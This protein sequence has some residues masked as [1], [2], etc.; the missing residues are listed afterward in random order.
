VAHDALLDDDTLWTVI[1]NDPEYDQVFVWYQSAHD[2][3]EESKRLL[4]VGLHPSQ[5][6]EVPWPC[7]VHNSFQRV[8]IFPLRLL[9]NVCVIAMFLLV[10]VIQ[11]FPMVIAGVVTV[12]GIFW[13]AVP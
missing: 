1:R 13:Y 12:T 9:W 11:K 5:P 7:Q 2:S 10:A 8:V 3:D 6:V 4:L